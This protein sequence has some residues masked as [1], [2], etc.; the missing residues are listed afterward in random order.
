MMWVES[1]P[2]SRFIY[3]IW[4]VKLVCL[5][6]PTCNVGDVDGCGR[7]QRVHQK[8]GCRAIQRSRIGHFEFKIRV[9]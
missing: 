9:L 2:F 3:P 6:G 1:K 5:V 7:V 8:G 4:V